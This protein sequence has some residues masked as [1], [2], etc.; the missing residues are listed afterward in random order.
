[1][2][3]RGELFKNVIDGNYDSKRLKRSELLYILKGKD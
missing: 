3:E 1:L 2:Y